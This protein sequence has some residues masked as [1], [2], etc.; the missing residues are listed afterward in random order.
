MGIVVTIVIALIAVLIT[1]AI[2]RGKILDQSD[3]RDVDVRLLP[4][5][6]DLRRDQ[7][8]ETPTASRRPR[9]GPGRNR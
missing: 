1:L 9:P 8:G 4:F 5:Y 2:R 6:N 3:L 7:D